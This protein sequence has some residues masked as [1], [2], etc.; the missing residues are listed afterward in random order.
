MPDMFIPGMFMPGMFAMSC[1]F[2]GFFFLV[3]VLLLFGVDERER[4]DPA[5]GDGFRVGI[6][7]PGISCDLT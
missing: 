4:F 2:A 7:M 3:E 6:F 1:F 5:A